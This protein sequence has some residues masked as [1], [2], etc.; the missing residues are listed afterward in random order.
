MKKIDELYELQHRINTLIEDK[1]T[2]QEI[3]GID[4]EKALGYM[5]EKCD[6]YYGKFLFDIEDG[7]E[8]CEIVWFYKLA[9][10]ALQVMRKK[11]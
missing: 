7:R 3:D 5:Q 9:I 1:I 2:R 11:R 8:M 10:E 4:I 6:H